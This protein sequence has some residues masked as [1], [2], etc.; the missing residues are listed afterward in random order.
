MHPIRKLICPFEATVRNITSWIAVVAK[1][2]AIATVV[3]VV[4]CC[5]HSSCASATEMVILPI[6]VRSEVQGHNNKPNMTY[7]VLVYWKRPCMVFIALWNAQQRQKTNKNLKR[8]P[9]DYL[10]LE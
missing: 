4:L 2:R 5:Y 8:N 3:A 6:T 10:Y 1:V 9:I 7:F